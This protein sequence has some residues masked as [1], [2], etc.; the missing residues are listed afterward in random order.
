MR[1]HAL[2]TRNE[3]TAAIVRLNQWPAPNRNAAIHSVNHTRIH[4]GIIHKKGARKQ[5]QN[6]SC[7]MLRTGYGNDSALSCEEDGAKNVTT[8]ITIDQNVR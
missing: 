3:E 7:C 2:R 5:A 4:N 8:K 6:K 1:L